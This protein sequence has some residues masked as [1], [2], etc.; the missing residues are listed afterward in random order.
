MK[1]TYTE[2]QLREAVSTSKSIRQV[3]A[4]LGLK[5]AGGNYSTTKK[6]I[7]QAGIDTTHFTGQGWKKDKTFG[8]KRPLEDYLSNE[9]GI[10][11]YQLK[12]RLLKEGVKTHQCEVCG[13][14]E[15]NGKPTPLELDHI[16]GNHSNNNLSNL[17]VICPNCHAQT[18]TYRGKNKKTS[19]NKVPLW[20]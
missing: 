15:W 18:E 6:R 12:L 4:K 16:D 11:S 3:L 2:Q 5:E 8:P 9:Y 1:H 14:T 19:L 10:Q 13:I 17:R 7:S 20:R